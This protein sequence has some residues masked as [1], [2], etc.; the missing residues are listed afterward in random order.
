[1]HESDDDDTGLDEDE[2]EILKD[3]GIIATLSKSGDRHNIKRNMW[4][5]SRMR[6]VCWELRDN[7]MPQHDNTQ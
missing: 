3:A 4:S 7:L 1:M 2:L 6:K 5:L